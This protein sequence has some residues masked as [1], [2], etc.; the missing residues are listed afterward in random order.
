MTEQRVKTTVVA[1]P[2]VEEAG[3]VA[4]TGSTSD[5]FTATM[6]SQAAGTVW[7][8]ESDPD[9][10]AVMANAGMAAMVGIAP[11]DEIEGMLA[12]QMLGCHNAAMECYRRAMISDQPSVV[13]KENLSQANKLS[14]TFTMLM[15][16]LGKYRGKGRQMVTVEHV[17]VNRGGQ[18][19]VANIAG[20]GGGD[21][22]K[23]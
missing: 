17:H 8:A 11:T 12:V 16:T 23:N 9:E 20:P 14:R 13:R 19:I 4:F 15:D 7:M 2:P 3:A 1:S 18:A 22:S 10:I 21:R 6:M 5:D